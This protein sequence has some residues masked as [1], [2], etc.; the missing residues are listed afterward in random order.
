MTLIRSRLISPRGTIRSET[1]RRGL[2]DRYPPVLNFDGPTPIIIRWRGT[3]YA[4]LID[5]ERSGRPGRR[6]EERRREGSRAKGSR[7][8]AQ[9]TLEATIAAAARRRRRRRREIARPAPHRQR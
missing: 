9:R 8:A 1:Q 5:T 2:V 4:S 3:N 6:A 7:F